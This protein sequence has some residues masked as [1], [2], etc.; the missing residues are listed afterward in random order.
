MDLTLGTHSNATATA[1]ARFSELAYPERRSNK[2]G[3]GSWLISRGAVF[4]VRYNAE[5][6][7]AYFAD[8]K[9]FRLL[10]FAGTD[11][12][13]DWFN[14]LDAIAQEK[15]PFYDGDG[16]RVHR[17]F[18]CH[19]DAIWGDLRNQL[20]LRRPAGIPLLLTG[21]SLGGAIATLAAARFAYADPEL[22]ITLYTFGSPRVGNA[23]FSKTL[24]ARLDGHYRYSHAL[25]P[26]P[27]VPFL[28]GRYR[29]AGQHYHFN[30]KLDVEVN[31]PVGHL[32]R[33]SLGPILRAAITGPGSGLSNSLSD[34]AID[35][36]KARCFSLE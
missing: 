27:W 16:D 1:A 25:D 3:L 32:L 2:G 33:R 18:G 36:Y 15:G 8:F 4:C 9:T 34:H 10:A 30:R 6:T 26:V 21:H 23:Q 17:G 12:P 28:F 22:L 20:S 24:D 13:A 35:S 11:E 19:L 29:H 14:S 5:N 7:E 31:P